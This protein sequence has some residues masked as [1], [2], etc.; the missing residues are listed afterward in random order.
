MTRQDDRFSGILHHLLFHCH[1][2][3][4]SHTRHCLFLSLPCRFPESWIRSSPLLP[5]HLRDIPCSEDTDTLP[6]QT[7]HFQTLFSRCLAGD[8]E[9]GSAFRHTAEPV[10]LSHPRQLSSSHNILHNDLLPSCSPSAAWS[11]IPSSGQYWCPHPG[12][13]CKCW[14]GSALPV[15]L[16]FPPPHLPQFL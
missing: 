10:P 9:S 14:S 12:C 8:T 2:G 5:P 13:F 15:P 11:S 6:N 4:L 7:L 1:N 3:P 16:T